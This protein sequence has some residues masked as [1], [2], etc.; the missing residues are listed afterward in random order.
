MLEGNPP[1]SWP[2]KQNG[3]RVVAATMILVMKKR[4]SNKYFEKKVRFSAQ[5]IALQCIGY[6]ALAI[7][8]PWAPAAKATP[9]QEVGWVL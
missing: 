7:G 5:I 9:L 2:W 4:V 3:T 1:Q 8:F 6:S